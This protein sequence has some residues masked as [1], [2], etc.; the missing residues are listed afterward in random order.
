MSATSSAST[1][2]RTSSG[3]SLAR[4]LL[5]AVALLGALGT[6][7]G[8]FLVQ[9]IGV[10]YRDGL[11]VTADGAA[12]ASLS[13]ANA[14]SI[15][16]DLVGLVETTATALEEAGELVVSASETTADLG[17]AFSTNI[18]DAL[19]GTSSIAERL[20]DLVEAVERFIPGNRDSLAED[21]RTLS[22]GLEPVPAQLEE[23]GAQLTESST[24]LS[25]AAAAL[26][27]IVD[28]LD[29]L[30]VSVEA[31]STRLSEVQA[32]S[33]DLAERAERALDRSR[34]DLW[35]VRLLVLVIGLG[36]VGAALAARR[37]VV[38]LIDT[39][40]AGGGTRTHTPSGTGT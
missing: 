28:Q 40:G 24:Q 13:A 35:L 20:A 36:V 21:L 16:T 8:L 19:V 14:E 37:A 29:G 17:D 6:V 5:T 39:D 10:T 31:A 3:A 30:A 9:R 11:E 34:S 26:D 23:L 18:A 1:T 22:D 12:L 2:V 25:D 7:L 32:L 15:A 4:H 33:V 27:T 38:L